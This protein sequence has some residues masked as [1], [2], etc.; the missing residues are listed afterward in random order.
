MHALA[1]A[2]THHSRQAHQV[3]EETPVHGEFPRWAVFQWFSDL[4]MMPSCVTSAFF[5][6][7]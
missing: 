5:Y 4:D 2:L 6:F 7:I 1:L 3:N